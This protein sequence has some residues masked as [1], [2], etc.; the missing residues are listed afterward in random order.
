MTQED[1][2]IQDQDDKNQNTSSLFAQVWDWAVI[3]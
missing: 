2:K 3:V 1:K